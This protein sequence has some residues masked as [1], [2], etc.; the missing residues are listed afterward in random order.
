MIALVLLVSAA[1]Q[2]ENTG[3]IIIQK[4]NVELYLQ[5]N[6]DVLIHYDDVIQVTSGDCPWITM[7]LPNQNFNV[8]NIG[9]AA[10]SV[11]PQ[12]LG[13]LVRSICNPG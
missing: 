10:S 1:A 13:R 3:G 2:A 4:Q 8:V 7:G 9:G 11:V 12:K 5:E 6:T